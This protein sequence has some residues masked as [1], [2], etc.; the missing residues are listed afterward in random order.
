MIIVKIKGGLGNQLFQYAF[1]RYLS[2]KTGHELIF[3]LSYFKEQSFRKFDLDKF[4]IAQYKKLGFIDFLYLKLAKRFP[5]YF[6]KLNIINEPDGQKDPE[7]FLNIL[8]SCYL[9]GY[10][11][12][13]T[14]FKEIQTVIK[15][16]FTLKDQLEGD[17][18]NIL[19]K[20]KNTNSVAIHVRRDDFVSVPQNAPYNVCDLNYYKKALE[21]INSKVSNSVFF[22]FSDDSSWCKE[23]IKTGSQTFFIDSNQDRPYID[24]FLYSQCKHAIMANST[25]SWWATWLNDNSDKVI[26]APYYYRKNAVLEGFVTDFQIRI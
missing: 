7:K 17:N 1:A 25:F 23:N 20:I 14:Y 11:Q 13:E 8:P 9:D 2:L 10:W 18:K 15:K 6:N 19:D 26:V 3:D 12:S 21:I 4:N 24:L 5:I 16:E 22:V